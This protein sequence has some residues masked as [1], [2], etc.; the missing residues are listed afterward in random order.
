MKNKHIGGSFDDFLREENL[1]EE[2]QN[3]AI[4][5]IINNTCLITCILV[6]VVGI[7]CILG[8]ILL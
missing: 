3:T 5:R 8:I 1:L 7:G 4:S 6:V 2:C